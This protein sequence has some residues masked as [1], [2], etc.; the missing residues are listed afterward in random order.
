MGLLEKGNHTE[1]VLQDPA[2]NGVYIFVLNGSV[3]VGDQILNRRDGY[4][5]SEIERFTLEATADAEILLME[6]PMEIQ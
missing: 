6:V 4:G 5:L 1:Y 2:N 3:R